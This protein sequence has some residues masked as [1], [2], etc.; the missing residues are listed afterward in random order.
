[1]NGFITSGQPMTNFGLEVAEHA[2][3]T[4]RRRNAARRI[5]RRY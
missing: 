4:S 1:M 5:V 2:E 3:K